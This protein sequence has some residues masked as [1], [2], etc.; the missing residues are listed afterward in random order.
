MRK[1]CVTVLMTIAAA[2]VA[3]A[4]SPADQKD[5]AGGPTPERGIF[6]T[7]YSRKSVRTFT[8]AP[9][10]RA[11]LEQLARAGMAAPTAMDK[12]PWAFVL[13][14]DK[15]VLQKLAEGLPYAKMLNEAG[16]AVVVC[17]MREKTL[18]GEG[19]EYWV[20]DCSAATQNVLLAAEGLGL[21]AVW[22]GVYPGA[23]RVALVRKVLGIPENVVPL[24]VIPVG[25][26]TG[27]EKPKDKFDEKNIHWNAW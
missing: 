2:T 16:G 26:P 18:P 3:W 21:G 1:I 14:T 8:G 23:E 17:G 19:G 10:P 25:H 24:N 9:V 15:A 20:Q 6:D 5:A 27:A 12:R 11:L 7:I 13:V 4:A 22:T